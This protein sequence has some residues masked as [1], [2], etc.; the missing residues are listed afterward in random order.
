MRYLTPAC[1]RA[2]GTGLPLAS[3]PDSDLAAW[4]D[5]AEDLVDAAC[6][7]DERT[8]LGLGAGTRSE[9]QIWDPTTRRFFYTAFPVPVQ[10]ISSFTIQYGQ[11]TTD[12]TPQVATLDPNGIVINNDLDYFEIITI[13]VVLAGV[14]PV[15]AFTGVI[16]P[17]ARCTYTAAYQVARTNVRLYPVPPAGA[18]PTTYDAAYRDILADA[19]YHSRLPF[20]DSTQPVSVSQNG[21][22]QAPSVYTVN[23]QDGSVIFTTPPAPMTVVTA[24]FTGTIPPALRDVTRN[25]L[26]QEVAGDYFAS[27]AGMMGFASVRSGVRAATR[28]DPASSTWRTGLTPFLRPHIGSA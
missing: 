26:V 9:A 4:I 10:S 3:V 18:Q 22:V 28:R 23:Y 5:A 14:A 21:V 1:L 8:G 27:Q 2:L 24:S 20:W 16:A 11:N 12:G 19:A 25:A 15:L 7:V 13:A 6:G 17:I